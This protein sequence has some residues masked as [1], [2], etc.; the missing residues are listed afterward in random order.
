MKLEPKIIEYIQNV[1]KVCKLIDIESIIIDSDSVR[2]MDPNKTRIVIHP[3]TIELPFKSIGL[4]RLSTLQSRL[5]L[6]KDQEGHYIDTSLKE[7]KDFIFS[8][9]LVAKGTKVQYRCADPLRIEAKGKSNHISLFKLTLSEHIVD[10][11]KRGMSAMS[12]DKITFLNNQNGTSFELSDVNNDVLSQTLTNAKIIIEG[13][14]P[15]FAY[16]YPIKLIL[17]AFK[18]NPENTFEIGQTGVLKILISG[19]TTYILPLLE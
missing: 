7:G 5:D 12:T 18:D 16:K 6:I 15:I 14:E 13:T 2:G 11:I 10:M 4:T 17:A 3:H 19:I 8:L 9:T 1:V